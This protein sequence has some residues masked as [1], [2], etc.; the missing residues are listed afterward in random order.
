M[1][2]IEKT[3]REGENIA[4]KA[5]LHWINYFKSFCILIL[6]VVLA[7]ASVGAVGM[8]LYV[9]IVAAFLVLWGAYLSIK[10]MFVEMVVTNKRVVVKKGIIAVDTDE[11]N[12][13]KVEGIE[14]EQPVWGRI[15]G[16]G[17][18]CFYGV[19]VGKL[20]FSAIKNPTEFK[21]KADELVAG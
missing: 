1:S 13:A 3:L 14:I 6:G 18:V 11:L 16:Y 8:E 9:W 17:D 15:L 12:N 10:L 19:G 20:R 7:I 2:Y 5:E 21:K 4:A